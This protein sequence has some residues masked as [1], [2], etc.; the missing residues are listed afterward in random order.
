MNPV[1]KSALTCISCPIGCRIAVGITNG[2]YFFSGNKCPKGA[3]FAK[4]EM[5]APMR[6]LT[7]TVRTIFPWMPVLPVRTREEVPKG[8]IPEIMRTLS[9]VIITKRIGIGE[10]IAVDIP[11]VNCEIIATNEIRND[12]YQH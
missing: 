12:E 3:E 10:T 9:K 8:K 7:T 2:E 1:Q 11:G 4:T 6:T 5:T